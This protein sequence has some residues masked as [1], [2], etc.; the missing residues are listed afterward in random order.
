MNRKT[1]LISAVLLNLLFIACESEPID[2]PVEEPTIEESETPEEDI[3]VGF[4]ILNIVSFSEIIT[5]KNLSDMTI[6]EFDSIE[7]PAGWMKNQP[8]ESEP[9]GGFFDK[10][11][12]DSLPNGTFIRQEHFSF[13]WEHVATVIEASIPIDPEGLLRRNTIQKYHTVEFHAP[14][15]VDLLISP[16]GE[17]YIRI[18]RDANR[19]SDDPTMPEGWTLEPVDITEDL[20]L[21]LPNPTINI[22]C[23]NEDSYQGP[24]EF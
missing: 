24:V 14:R 23:D 5:W 13:E 20:T 4:E 17:K 15:T 12:I 2:L 1:I 19:T 21:R 10:S 22:R 16:E 18:T 6:A 7:I 9:D 3:K 8:R 11:P